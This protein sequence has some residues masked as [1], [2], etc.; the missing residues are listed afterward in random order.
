M[1]ISKTNTIKKNSNPGLS[2]LSDPELQQLAFMSIL[3]GFAWL[4]LQCVYGQYK[5]SHFLLLCLSYFTLYLEKSG[6]VSITK[7]DHPAHNLS[8]KVCAAT[9]VNLLVTRVELCLY[10]HMI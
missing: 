8:S 9:G 1:S 4:P 7:R 6:N 3:L 5:L 2:Q 10:T